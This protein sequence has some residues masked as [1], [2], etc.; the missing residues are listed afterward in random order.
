MSSS[1]LIPIGGSGGQKKP[2]LDDLD[3]E[4]DDDDLNDL[5]GLDSD[6]E[7][8]KKGNKYSSLKKI[9][10]V[11]EDEK[12]KPSPS[13]IITSFSQDSQDFPS[14]KTSFPKSAIPSPIV[15]M[16]QSAGPTRKGPFFEDPALIK[17][18]KEEEKAAGSKPAL[19]Q[20][21]IG[22]ILNKIG[23]M[24]DLDAGL[25]GSSG[26]S[27][28]PAA[29]PP[30]IITQ[31]PKDADPGLASAFSPSTRHDGSDRDSPTGFG[32]GSDRERGKPTT[33][34]K[35]DL[36]TK[37]ASDLGNTSKRSQFSWEKNKP[38]SPVNVHIGLAKSAT[39]DTPG[40]KSW[41]TM[42]KDDAGLKSP[43]PNGEEDKIRSIFGSRRRLDKQEEKKPA[44]S[45]DEWNGSDDDLFASMGL[46]GGK[47]DTK[48][49][50]QASTSIATSEVKSPAAVTSFNVSSPIVSGRNLGEKE[51]EKP[52]SLAASSFTPASTPALGEPKISSPV[53]T[54]MDEAHD[55]FVPSFLIESGNRRR[56][57]PPPGSGTDTS[58]STQPL[59]SVSGTGS[60][61]LQEVTNTRTPSER[62]K[63]SRS[64]S[65]TSH[66]SFANE[67][68]ESAK[69]ST[70]ELEE[71]KEVLD[72]KPKAG[73]KNETDSTSK[74]RGKPAKK[75]AKPVAKEHDHKGKSKGKKVIEKEESPSLSEL[76][77]LSSIATVSS[78]D[79]EDEDDE[80]DKEQDESEDISDA[81]NDGTTTPTK[82]NTSSK[83]ESSVKFKS[84]S[85]THSASHSRSRK[86]STGSGSHKHSQKE[87][88][89]EKEKDRRERESNEA[90]AKALA[91]SVEAEKVKSAE[92]E[93]LKKKLEEVNEKLKV[94][95]GL[96]KDALS[97]LE[98]S[99]KKI[100]EL[101]KALEVEK[102]E[103]KKIELNLR[104]NEAKL[105][106]ERISLREKFA[107]EKMKLVELHQA[108]IA[109]LKETQLQE[110]EKAIRNEKQAISEI[111]AVEIA[112]AR[113]EHDKELAQL[114]VA[115]LDEMAKVI[116]TADAA[117]QIEILTQKMEATSKFVDSMQE[118]VES[119]HSYSIKERET[120]Y[121]SRERQLTEL[122]RH[123]LKQQRD[124]DEERVKLRARSEAAEAMLQEMK[125]EQENE[126]RVV[127]EERRMLEEQIAAARTERDLAQQQLHRERLDFVRSRE[128]WALEKR[129]AALAASDEQKTLAMEKAMLEA[130]RDAVAEIEV[131]VG[132]YRGRE[133]AQITADRTVLEKEAHSIAIKKADLHREAAALRAEWIMLEAEKAKI[134]SELDAFQKGWEQ[135]EHGMTE[136]R[137]LHESAVQERKK[138]EAIHLEGKKLMATLQSEK[139]ELEKAKKALESEKN[140][141][142]LA[143]QRV[144]EER[145]MLAN[146]RSH[147]T[148]DI[149]SAGERIP[150]Q[151]RL[152]LAAAGA[153]ANDGKT[154]TNDH[155]KDARL[156]SDAPTTNQKGIYDK[157]QEQPSLPPSRR[158]IGTTTT[159][160]PH[161]KIGLLQNVKSFVI[162]R[163]KIEKE[164][165]AVEKAK[166]VAERLDKFIIGLQLNK[167]KLSDQTAFLQST[168]ASIR[169]GGADLTWNEKWAI[170]RVQ[171]RTT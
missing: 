159:L 87:K 23:D 17:K 118:K 155:K 80:M 38:E 77:S 131:E 120:S 8:D 11:K 92:L 43:S 13:K 133:E 165:E 115:H 57:G 62:S 49:P 134:A 41:M 88:E 100:V 158:F 102:M 74:D 3:L 64:P 34:S 171:E 37:S 39:T 48:K 24:D 70:K 67:K 75:D 117:R 14:S 170:R 29:K 5:L 86:G 54:K 7:K 51:K 60:G 45:G 156:K 33:S 157:V 167:E 25:F 58:Q 59:S 90:I 129:K 151:K 166:E 36:S 149:I 56:R 143:R 148:G 53:K 108:E 93:A 144:V 139:L 10:E 122:Q 98:V 95:E 27:K 110:V 130:R 111:V 154:T 135:A 66:L 94:E 20:D 12:P 32:A 73:Q 68:S 2:N 146:E 161:S 63:P 145:I 132:R 22:S 162:D 30:P 169:S 26:F 18:A 140:G 72:P 76:S 116:S 113:L 125:H 137:A 128:A 19:N 84:G 89:K 153:H 119:D 69:R 112:K 101:E 107:D 4:I 106:E 168:N 50:T 35:E 42:N 82:S 147:G 15:A 83:A 99:G 40:G 79:T 91:T 6:D 160:L 9:A 97:A 123:I 121:Q 52:R 78:T 163:Q 46:G 142:A 103:S 126:R 96:K 31:S 136:A 164:Q 55:D 138:A 114:K 152:D 65:M 1:G 61:V 71:K 105:S 150:I 44:D 127:D 81:E 47:T 109:A 104:S 124:L 85:K 21:D 141:L 28:K 16:P